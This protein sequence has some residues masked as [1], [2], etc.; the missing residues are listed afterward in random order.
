MC[1]PASKAGGVNQLQVQFAS[2][3]QADGQAIDERRN[4]RRVS[5]CSWHARFARELCPS[6]TGTREC[7]CLAMCYGYSPPKVDRIWIWVC[8][9]KIPIYPIFYLLRGD[10]GP[11]IDPITI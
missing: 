8:Y 6:F 9:N 11:N 4:S 2:C 7:W 1:V 10:Y 5:C 3:V